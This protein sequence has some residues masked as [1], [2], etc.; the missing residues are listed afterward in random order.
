VTLAACGSDASDEVTE[1]DTSTATGADSVP[2]ASTDS[3]SIDATSVD[4]GN[5]VRIVT[6]FFGND[7]E[8]PATPTRIVAADDIALA[9]LL[10]LGVTPIGTAVNRNS[11]PDFL[12]ERLA[13][14][15]DV[16]AAN[17]V[18]VNLEALAA[19]H[20]DV[21]FTV[22]VDW[23]EDSYEAVRPIAPTFAYEYGYAS[24][25]QIRTNMTE[26]GRALGMEDAAA[27]EVQRL[28]DHV[29]ELRARVEELGI[30]GEPVSVLRVF[31]DGGLSLRHGSP[32]SV[33]LDEIGISR[34][35]N[36]RSIEDFAT[37]VS[38]ENLDQVDAYAIYVY[39]DDTADTSAYDD[40][41]ASPLWQTL[42]AV[43]ND[44]IYLVDGGVW[45]GI[46]LAAGH[47]ILNDIEATLLQ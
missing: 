6:D 20:P 29:A 2:A 9:N 40:M 24:G 11:V 17:D 41:I 18:G 4:E 36:Q 12:G 28:D 22:G 32:E 33:L 15:E 21:I 25:E 16:S 23:Y 37:D 7:V 31:S 39:V 14:I 42:D 19:L 45:N 35:P 44:R 26:L 38:L 46:S 30:A 5:E 10:D 8:I 27:R 43:Q 47:E 34:P 13:G 3:G 1:P